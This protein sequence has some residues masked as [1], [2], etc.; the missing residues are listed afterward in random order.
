[1]TN[2]RWQNFLNLFRAIDRAQRARSSAD[3]YNGGL[4]RHD[5][6]VDDLQA[7]R[8]LDRLLP[9]RRQVRLPRRSE[10]RR[11]GLFEKIDRRAGS[12]F[13]PW[14]LLPRPMTVAR[15]GQPCRSRRNGKRFGIYYTP[16]EFTRFIVQNTI[17]AVVE[18]RCAGL[19]RR[20]RPGREDLESDTLPEA[21]RLLANCGVPGAHQGLR[22]GVRQRRLSH[23]GL[24]A[25]R[26]AIHS[27]RRQSP[28]AR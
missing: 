9:H 17:D 25:P 8:R 28:R 5:T 1:M 21:G 19:A 15:T 2:P 11:L 14:G 27:A 12:G 22:S 4:F 20:T 23:P 18:E 13:A 26:R 7:R 10:R 6:E 24:R 3:G 16:P